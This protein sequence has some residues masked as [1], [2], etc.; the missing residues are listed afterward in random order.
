MER[1]CYGINDIIFDAHHP[2][3]YGI[4]SAF[5]LQNNKQTI[6]PVIEIAEGMLVQWYGARG[7]CIRIMSAN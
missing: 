7:H 3:N 6:S 1:N 5:G 4:H 2:S